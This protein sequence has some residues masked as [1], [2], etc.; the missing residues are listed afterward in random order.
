MSEAIK[1]KILKAFFFAAK[2]IARALLNSGIGFREFSQ[3]AKAEFIDVA[4]NEYG[5]RG[6]QTNT[7]RI[8]VMTG[9]A[10]KQVAKIRDSSLEGVDVSAKLSLTGEVLHLW[11]TDPEFIDQ[12]GKPKDIPVNGRVGSFES[13]VSRSEG[14]IPLGAIKKELL[15]LCSIEELPNKKLRILSKSFVPPGLSDRLE[16]GFRFGFK[17]LAEMINEDIT[18]QGDFLRSQLRLY[19]TKNIA[20]KDLAVF[21]KLSMENL[22]KFCNE[23]DDFLI[24]ME[25]SDIKND[26]DIGIGLFYFENIDEH[27]DL[28]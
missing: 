10:R 28:I 23:F 4:A 2:P 9:I 11:F 27:E 7:S 19:E 15:R 14:D 24:S 21:Q 3:C 26:S 12:N 17:Q 6:R 8:S 1:T 20:K 16:F 5:V 18:E 13:L 25:S 22:N